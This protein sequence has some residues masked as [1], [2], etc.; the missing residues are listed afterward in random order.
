VPYL[1]GL[2]VTNNVPAF[3]VQPYISPWAN[4]FN[5]SKQDASVSESLIHYLSN[6]VRHG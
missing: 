6:F 3:G 1:M 2:P 5:F 4:I